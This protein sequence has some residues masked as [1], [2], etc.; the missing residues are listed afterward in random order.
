MVR[1]AGECGAYAPMATRASEVMLEA[2]RTDS[3]GIDPDVSRIVK[4]FL[5]RAAA[6]NAEG[7]A[8]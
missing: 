6:G 3:I 2:S 1:L 8:S 4:L 7:G 5:E